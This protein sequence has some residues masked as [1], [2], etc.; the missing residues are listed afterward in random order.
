MKSRPP[1]ERKFLRQSSSPHASLNR[2]YGEGDT[3]V[4]ALRDVSI[5]IEEARLTA[6]MGPS[7][8]GK[9]TLMHILAGLDKPSAGSVSIAGVEIT[10]MNDKQLTRLRRDHI[11][12]VFQFFNLLPM[13]TAEE[14]ILL[15][16]SIAGEKPEREWLEELLE[17]V[18]IAD[19]RTHRPSQLSG[20][21]QQRVS[22][23]R[24][25]ISKPSVLF[26]DEPT[27]NLDSNTSKDV[28]AL[29]RH[30]VEE[31][32][33]T[34]VM[35]THDA[36]RSRARRPDP[37]PRR[38]PDRQGSPRLDGSGSARRHAG[39]ERT[40]IAVALKGLLGRKTRAI[41]TALAIVLGTGWS[42]RTF[43]F[44]DTL[45]QAFNGVFST[46]YEQASVVV[47]GKQIVTGAANTPSVP[48]SLVARIKAV[49]G[50]EAASGGFLF[51]T[52][53]LVGSERQGDR[54]R[55]TAVRLRR[56]PGRQALHTARPDH[57]PLALRAGRD[58][59]RGSD[60]R[61]GALRRRRHDRRQGNRARPPLHDHRTG[62]DPRCVLRQRNPR[63]VRRRAPR[64][65]CSA[66]RAATT[67][68]RSSAAPAS[69][70]V[71]CAARIRPLL[72]ERRWCGR[73]RQRRHPSTS[74]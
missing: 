23:A 25:L 48:A 54:Q 50:V 36:Q 58:R 31:L 8:S 69:R 66:S 20:G 11:G 3:A 1:Q 72:P 12:F 41:L 7:G 60:R 2:R 63:R 15:P 59:D 17:T 13:L 6:I 62:R 46:P 37:L 43:I 51:A 35:V 4:H 32:G 61:E 19:R 28:L 68:S 38:R 9:S 10:G 73:R 57:R 33:Q 29:L 14:N 5:E 52:V 18:G 53:K 65:S 22:I 45:N 24:A 42:A 70:R 26:A 56:R 44:T 34:T 30:S 49:P 39:G 64:R 21:Q 67:A 71:R 47:S 55:W 27:G 16:L 40:M 74:R